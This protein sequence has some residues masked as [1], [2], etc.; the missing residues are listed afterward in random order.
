MSLRNTSLHM[1]PCEYIR[2]IND[3][4]QGDNEKDELIRKYCYFAEKHAKWLS[5]N[6]YKIRP[7]IWQNKWTVNEDYAVLFC[8][9][10]EKTYKTYEEKDG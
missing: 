2:L 3:L 8:N 7:D 4:A 10:I 1:T 6:L 9:R 5:R